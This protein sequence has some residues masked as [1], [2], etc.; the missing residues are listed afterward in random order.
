MTPFSLNPESEKFM[1]PIGENLVVY[2]SAKKLLKPKNLKN[3]SNNGKNQPVPT[4]NRKF[5]TQP[6]NMN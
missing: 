4:L 3:G 2:S 5:I 1:M 6:D